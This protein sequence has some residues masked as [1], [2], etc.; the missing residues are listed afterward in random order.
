VGLVG[1]A[2]SAALVYLFAWRQGVSAYR[3]ILVGVGVA[4][5]AQSITSCLVARAEMR[6]ARTALTWLVGSVGMTSPAMLTVLA[7]AVVLS[8]P[9]GLY[10]SRVL[11]PLELGDAMARVLGARTQWDRLAVLGLGVAVVAAA[12]AAAGPIAFIA[13]IAGPLARLLL[14]RAGHSILVTVLTGAVLLQTADLIAQHALPW[15]VST[16]VITGVFGAPYIAW[17]L[18]RAARD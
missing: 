9:A 2:S 12:T 11:R 13:M 16:G 17:V 6:D 8:V 5:F 4:A 1:A 14:R 15:Q 3:F 7:V 10:A 18:I